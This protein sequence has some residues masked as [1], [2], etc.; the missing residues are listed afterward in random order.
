M[1]IVEQHGTRWRVHTAL[2]LAET[3]TN[4]GT[5]ALRQPFLIFDGLLREVAE[6]ASAI[7]DPEL[8]R[9]MMQLTLLSVADPN[10]PDYDPATVNEYLYGDG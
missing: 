8:I 2:L 5:S 10:S 3:L 1:A 9:L 7:G 6:R 4:A